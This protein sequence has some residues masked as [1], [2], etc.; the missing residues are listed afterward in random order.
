[1]SSKPETLPHPLS[2][3][4]WRQ[5]LVSFR[6]AEVWAWIGVRAPGCGRLLRTF[7]FGQCRQHP[8]GELHL[9]F[10]QLLGQC[11]AHSLCVHH[12]VRMYDFCKY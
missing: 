7:G 3:G 12:V 6:D 1:M 5:A 9:Q 10:Q 2:G 8:V 4:K 11:L